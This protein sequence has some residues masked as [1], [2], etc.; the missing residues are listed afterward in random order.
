MVY[1]FS[2]YFCAILS[3]GWGTCF[4]ERLFFL[5]VSDLEAPYRVLFRDL[6][7]CSI[8]SIIVFTAFWR[9]FGLMNIFCLRV[10]F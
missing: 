8:S 2:S 1:K 3:M 7:S 5:V 6:F 9:A 4:F 10:F